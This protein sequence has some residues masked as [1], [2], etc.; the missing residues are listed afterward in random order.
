V[1]TLD[2]ISIATEGYVCGGG[3]N[4]IAIATHGYVCPVLVVVIEARG[5]DSS[6]RGLRVEQVHRFETEAMIRRRIL[7]EDEE[8][9][10]IISTIFG[11]INDE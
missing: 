3:P 10:M 5:G 11:V 7:Q 6:K 1:S 2:D 8:I 9:L 4:D